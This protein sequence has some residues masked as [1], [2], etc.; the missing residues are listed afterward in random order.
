MCPHG[1]YSAT[2]QV[3]TCHVVTVVTKEALTFASAHCVGR[4]APSALL[5]IPLG[6]RFRG[7]RAPATVDGAP[8]NIGLGGR[9][10]GAWH[11]PAIDESSQDG[12]PPWPELAP[13]G[14]VTT[15][16]RQVHFRHRYTVAPLTMTDANRSAAIMHTQSICEAQG[17][18][19]SRI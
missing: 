14:R 11:S 17:P 12:R 1:K 18:P 16:E 4:R 19:H 6:F 15:G 5:N 3:L 7:W 10:G 8:A 9:T 2:L 13:A